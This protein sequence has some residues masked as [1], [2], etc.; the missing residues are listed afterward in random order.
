MHKLTQVVLGILLLIP[1]ISS[2]AQTKKAKGYSV[3]EYLGQ[4]NILDITLSP[5][6][7]FLVVVTMENNFDTNKEEYSLWRFILDEK[8]NPI[9]KIKLTADTYR[10]SNLKWDKS[11][12][13]LFFLSKNERG[14]NLFKIDMD[15]GESIPVFNKQETANKL[16]NYEV[17][18]EHE[19]LFNSNNCSRAH[20][21][22][23]LYEDVIYMSDKSACESSFYKLN[24]TNSSIDS[25][26]TLKYPIYNFKVSPNNQKMIFVSEDALASDRKVNFLKFN[27]QDRFHSYLFDFTTNKIEKQ[28]TDDGGYESGKWL[29]DN[30]LVFKN[31]G[32]PSKKEY[33]YLQGKLYEFNLTKSTYKHLGEEF[34]GAVSDFDTSE[35]TILFTASSSTQLNLYEI[36]KQ[37]K[38][39]QLTYFEGKMLDFSYS[40]EKDVYAFA[41][42]T[43]NSIPQ[44]YI[45]KGEDKL[46]TPIKISAFNENLTKYPKPVVETVKWKNSE[47]EIIEGVLIR[48]PN[49]SK[50]DKLPLIVDIHGGPWSA[51]YEALTLGG[52][53][54]YYYGSLLASKGFLVLQPNYTGSIGNGDNYVTN[55]LKSPYKKPTDDIITGVEYLINKG[56]VDEDNMAVMGASYGGVLTNSIITETNMFKAA[57]PSCGSWNE[58]ADYGT[59]DGDILH[60]YLFK[61]THTWDNFE[62]YWKESP[63]SKATKIKT[64]TLITHGEK[65]SR[66]P[67]H[68][69]KAMYWA[70]QELGVEVEL[71]LFKGEGHLYRKPKNKLKKVMIELNWLEKYLK[72]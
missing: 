68:H 46:R 45:A 38:V 44:I 51:R 72:W 36:T 66:V 40:K 70:L 15:G 29:D 9:N 14:R 5:N 67:T 13:S 59:S 24:Y 22:N 63:I 20:D 60:T 71:V 48:P 8:G 28:L 32:D 43:K 7:V 27:K 62:S 23:S 64:P 39:N 16:A 49:T 47:N 37:Q 42:I 34:E 50:T 4:T 10:K 18:G 57:L 52:L 12:N 56:W 6:G 2:N 65:D 31:N 61:G 58:V 3:K 55:I 21:E 54:Y 19:I 41:V 69:A 53:Q 25:I 26:V 33:N 11:G 17:F 30:T 35:E 1:I